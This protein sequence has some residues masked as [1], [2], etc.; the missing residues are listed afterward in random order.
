[1]KAARMLSTA[2][3][4]DYRITSATPKVFLTMLSF[5]LVENRAFL[6]SLVVDLPSLHES[7]LIFC[8]RLLEIG[9][10]SFGSSKE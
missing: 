9:T 6:I 8:S 2:M 4:R 1:M 5:K 10:S 3:A 7:F